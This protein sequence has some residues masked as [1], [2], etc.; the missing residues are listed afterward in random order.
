MSRPAAAA[1]FAP[2]RPALSSARQPIASS[3][4]SPFSTSSPLLASRSKQVAK[5]KKAHVLSLRSSREA[6]D[7]HPP[8][9][10]LGH[11][12]AW[13]G[14]RLQRTILTPEDVWSGSPSGSA[15]PQPQHYLPGL[16]ES[17]RDMLFGAVP[18]TTLTLGTRDSTSEDRV[19]RQ[20][21]EQE[22]Q[23]TAMQKILD[24]RNAS[25]QGIEVVN[26]QRIIDEFGRRRVVEGE[27]AVRFEGEPQSG[28]SEVQGKLSYIWCMSGS[29]RR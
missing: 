11:V 17:D 26:R 1:V 15:A 3:S 18:H 10:V 5:R 13:D 23:V 22:H 20:V 24:L 25:K 9:P 2:L 29:G 4:T 16:S 19:M 8:N 7:A 21:T 28:G 27:G 6:E 14:C 12:S